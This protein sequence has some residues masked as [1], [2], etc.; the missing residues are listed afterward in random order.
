MCIYYYCMIKTLY[1]QE[2]LSIITSD[3]IVFFLAGPT[4]ITYKWRHTLI[5][6]LRTKSINTSEKNIYFIFPESKFYK[7][8]ISGL[9]NDIKSYINYND[10][11]YQQMLLKFRHHFSFDF[12][13]QMVWTKYALCIS[14]Y[15]IYNMCE[16]STVNMLEGYHGNMTLTIPLDQ[17]GTSKKW[18]YYNNLSSDKTLNTINEVVLGGEACGDQT[19]WL[20]QLIEERNYHY[21][22]NVQSLIDIIITF[23]A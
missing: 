5:T 1:S 2:D 16:H 7:Y 6:L 21:V 19:E 13:N 18:I 9:G 14:T 10:P 4:D 17:I 8:Q 11:Y 20:I 12:V 3:D 15:V 22:K 23:S